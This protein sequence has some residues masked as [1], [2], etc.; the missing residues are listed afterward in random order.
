MV[1]GKKMKIRLLAFD[2]DGTTLYNHG[3][4]SEANRAALEAAAEKG[5]LLVP[6]T[7][8]L[9]SFI[10]S[11]VFSLPARYVLFSNGAVVYD[12]KTDQTLVS[13]LIP[14]EQAAALMELCDR[15]G[16]FYEFYTDG[17][18]VTFTDH[19]HYAMD[20]LHFPEE[21]RR[22][23]RKHY[24]DETDHP[25]QY[26]RERNIRPEKLNLP[27]VPDEVREPFLQAV[28][29]LGT[30]E[31]SYSLRDNLEFNAPGVHK[32]KGL[33]EL[34]RVLGIDRSEVMA[35][36]DSENDRGM[37]E[38]AGVSVAMGNANEAIRSIAR[39]T[40]DRCE[41]DGAAHAVKRFILSSKAV[42]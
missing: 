28:G 26:I 29:E 41:D 23:L 18:A 14:V 36:G 6:A 35:M 17:G 1:W 25:A 7:G 8:R 31:I 11:S 37:L 32:G 16:L 42:E 19:E 12:K 3:E 4:L 9:Y 33:A 22:F 34:C 21:K 30:F 13:N 15:F 24:I 39:F 10:P 5:V 38:F 20:V 2:L 27:Y 40:T